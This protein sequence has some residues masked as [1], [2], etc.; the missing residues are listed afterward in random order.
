M[1]KHPAQDYLEA[2]VQPPRMGW[3]R[4]TMPLPFK[5]Y[6]NC[7]QIKCTYEAIEQAETLTESDL[8]RAQIG[9][10]LT[11]IYGLTR[12]SYVV[13]EGGLRFRAPFSQ[14]TYHS[15]FHQALL[16]PIPSGGALFPCELYLL[17][18]TGKA[19]P[20]GLYHYDAAH[21]AL[22]IIRQ[23]DYSQQLRAS[24]AHPGDSLPGY[25]LLLSSFFWK[26]GFKYG[27]FSY[28]LQGLDI[29]AVIGQSIIVSDHYHLEATIHY[30]FLDKAIDELIGLDPLHESVYAVITLAPARRLPLDGVDTHEEEPIQ[31]QTIPTAELLESVAYW[32]LVEAIHTASLLETRSAFC[33]LRS[34]EPI[35]QAESGASQSIPPANTSL[36]LW[37]A[38]YQ[39]HSAAGF[40]PALLSEQQIAQLLLA[41][42]HGTNNDLDGRSDLL[43]HTLLYC[44]VNRVENIPSGIYCYHPEEHRLAVVSAG[45]VQSK[46]QE[47]L[48]W[49][50]FNLFQMSICL[51]PVANYKNGFKV[52]GDRWYRMQNMEAGII[53]QRLYLAA[54]T[55][56]LGCRANLGFPVPEMD[57]F[58][59][60]P[61]DYTSMLQ[62][63]VAPE[64]PISGH[65][66]QS[67][68][69]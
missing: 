68:L 54:A 11:D 21:H 35:K 38:R 13:K 66:A 45:E 49:A 64:H 63:L 7:E 1:Q 12:Q 65:Y 3:K 10:M 58:L 5:L 41:S 17:V 34:L 22:D 16:R 37:Q 43:L 40:R 8:E 69:L 18:G 55:L 56:K 33:P 57:K 47:L 29:G 44:V 50:N 67:L 2:D 59:C 23:G 42:T 52:Y 28:R 51:L 26:N 48:G 24:L 46:F 32:P 14:R 61:E 30:Q 62:V 31:Y 60:L 39:R 36:D 20:A 4:S 9:Q 15:A 6:R 19:F 25:T 27:A 53:A